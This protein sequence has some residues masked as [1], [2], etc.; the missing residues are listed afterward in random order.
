MADLYPYEVFRSQA[1]KPELS[2][3][4]FA[5][6]QLP[7]G[8]VEVVTINYRWSSHVFNTR[9]E[10]DRFL[11]TVKSFKFREVIPLDP[12]K[13]GK[14]DVNALVFEKNK[15]ES[16]PQERAMKHK[17]S[18]E[19]KIKESKES[20]IPDEENVDNAEQKNTERQKME[21]PQSEEIVQDVP[22]GGT[23]D[24]IERMIPSFTEDG[25]KGVQSM[26]SDLDDYVQDG[27]NPIVGA[28]A[29][30]GLDLLDNAMSF[31]EGLPK[32]ILDARKFGEGMAKGT[33]EGVMEDLS[34]LSNVLPQGKVLKVIDGVNAIY[35]SAKIIDDIR[36]IPHLPFPMFLGALS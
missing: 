16:N 14:P 31:A 20:T 7:N 15:S 17:P 11:S 24:V 8:C 9:E 36:K 6:F 19:K 12:L 27:G 26:K 4:E 33:M 23:L 2:T 3:S 13:Y 34:R 28:L 29:A 5:A 1:V 32:G 35:N 18:S 10:A 21:K 30:S 22:E 25:H